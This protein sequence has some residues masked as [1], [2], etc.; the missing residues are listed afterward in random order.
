MNT[1]RTKITIPHNAGFSSLQKKNTVLITDENVFKL[2]SKKFRNY[3]TIVLKAGEQSK[4]Q[5]TVD[6]IIEELIQSGVNRTTT[7]IGVGGGVVT[8]IT[9]Y[10]ASIYMRG[11]NFGFV[12]TTLLALIDASIGG[13]NGID[14]GHYKNM[15]GTINQP[16]F[17]LH[18][19]SFLSTL[20]E[21]E[22]HNGFA[23]IIKHACIKDATMF[24]E[25][26]LHSLLYYRKK[27][28]P[29]G[30]L[31]KKNAILKTKIV[32]KDVNEKGDRKLLNFGHTLGHA[33]ENQY[34]LSHGHAISIGMSFA[35]ELSEKIWRFK[36]TNSVIGLLQQYEL[37]TR[38]SFDKEKVFNVLKMDKKSEINAIKY[39]LLKKIGKGIITEID[40]RE[41][42]NFLTSY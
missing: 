21:L 4:I 19:Y 15:V 24:N 14:I 20:P 5:A 38:M 1:N 18:D 2:H 11:I 16:Q 37:P 42:E 25:L 33:L 22:W 31:I 12:P 28:L 23:E 35:C 3:Q 29:L 26:H 6:N 41:V 34:S 8:D 10:V 27:K 7:L 32:A 30:L 40:L 39:I 17:I 13:K 36:Q 9:G